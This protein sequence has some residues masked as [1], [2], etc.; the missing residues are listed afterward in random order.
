MLQQQRAV[1]SS[2]NLQQLGAVLITIYYLTAHTRNLSNGLRC[3]WAF[4]PSSVLKLK[5]LC[6]SPKPS[7][8]RRVWSAW[9]QQRFCRFRCAAVSSGFWSLVKRIRGWIL[10][11]VMHRDLAHHLLLVSPW[12]ASLDR[13]GLCSRMVVKRRGRNFCIKGKSKTKTNSQMPEV[14]HQINQSGQG[15]EQ[16]SAYQWDLKCTTVDE[17]G[18]QDIFISPAH[19]HRD[20]CNTCQRVRTCTEIT[21]MPIKTHPAC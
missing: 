3:C 14:R 6:A 15:R 11:S 18:R 12:Q 2:C 7:W 20:R 16:R 17:K 5:V 10:C 21:Q 19:T 13:V 8:Y 4:I 9:Q 1:I